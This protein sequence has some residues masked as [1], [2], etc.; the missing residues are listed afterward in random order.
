MGLTVTS[1]CIALVV[2][3]AALL[4]A[5]GGSDTGELQRVEQE[6][7]PPEQ[8]SK[9]TVVDQPLQGSGSL[10]DCGAYG[11]SLV[12][13][14]PD[15]LRRTWENRDYDQPWTSV[16][17]ETP[18]HETRLGSMPGLVQG[19]PSQGAFFP[20]DEIRVSGTAPVGTTLF[21]AAGA[22]LDDGQHYLAGQ[23]LFKSIGLENGGEA[24]VTI[25][26]ADETLEFRLSRPDGTTVGP[27]VVY[28]PVVPELNSEEAEIELR[29]ALVAMQAY[30]EAHS[31]DYG[32][33][34]IGALRRI[35][36]SLDPAVAV[37]ASRP[38][39]YCVEVTTSKESIHYRLSDNRIAAG[40][41]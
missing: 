30:G 40:P 27:D 8:A 38:S 1:L 7:R 11:G 5:C 34:T 39:D 16:T 15:L 37:S 22:R 6:P 3:T 12:I 35:D 4:A 29:R 10:R 17:V 31:G 28:R 18:T 26:L 36:P 24:V 9:P 19:L 21:V 2:G 23:A 25:G 13:C 33:V 41:C 20:G 32:R 14:H